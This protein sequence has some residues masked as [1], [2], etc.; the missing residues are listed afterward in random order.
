MGVTY[1]LLSL[2]ALL[3]VP[4]TA[5]IHATLSFNSLSRTTAGGCNYASAHAFSYA[6][7][8]AMNWKACVETASRYSAML[9]GGAYSVNPAWYGHRNG[10]YAM[11]GQ[12]S[13][14]IQ[15]GITTTTNCVIGTDTRSTTTTNTLSSFRT[16][17]GDTWSYQDYG[18]KYYDECV[19]LASTAGAIIITP[20]TLGLSTSLEYWSFSVHQCCTYEWINTAGTGFSYESLGGGARS[21]IKYCMVGWI[22]YDLTTA[23]P[24]VSPTAAPTVSPTPQ[25][26][27]PVFSP[28]GGT[29]PASARSLVVS[30]TTGTSSCTMR[31]TIQRTCT[32]TCTN[33][34]E[35]TPTTTYGTVGT[36]YTFQAH[37]NYFATYVIRAI[38]YQAGY[39]DS[40][41][42]ISPQFYV[43]RILAPV[44]FTPNDATATGS[45]RIISVTFDSPDIA[46]ADGTN[47][48]FQSTQFRF[49]LNGDVTATTGTL[50][51]G[52]LFEAS[53]V[54][55]SWYI[56][57]IS[58]RSGWCDS[59]VRASG[60]YTTHA[61]V[62]TP[63]FSPD[64]GT[65]IATTRSISFNVAS[66]TPSAVHR[67]VVH[68][69]DGTDLT[70]NEGTANSFKLDGTN[71]LELSLGNTTRIQV[72]TLTR[73]AAC[74]CSNE[75]VHLRPMSLFVFSGG[76]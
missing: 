9:T 54:Q 67:R 46:A 65:H 69:F 30:I 70:L 49:L 75:H 71:Y 57:A 59:D 51:K 11:T 63:T 7:M 58:T 35:G 29:H 2:S 12:W 42:A 8:G 61:I 47:S 68:Q 73:S 38:A 74:S 15:Q 28:N 5:G 17:D 34:D 72:S 3:V 1:A 32:G 43:K 19:L 31:Y 50:G 55:T 24:T 22:G 33:Y 18:Q 4:T 10:A 13:N 27:T 45:A 66:S 36:S 37:T 52:H 26:Q 6:N 40:S 20:W 25:V 41:V 23:A 56:T 21:S 64:G 44:Y 76:L 48:A 16:Y 60:T 14:Y 39:G 62:A 53:S